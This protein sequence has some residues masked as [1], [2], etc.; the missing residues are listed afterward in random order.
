M[1]R[2]LACSTGVYPKSVCEHDRPIWSRAAEEQQRLHTMELTPFHMTDGSGDGVTLVKSMK[3][4]QVDRTRQSAAC[5]NSLF[6]VGTRMCCC[7]ILLR[8]L[9]T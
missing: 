8:H 4:V 9:S 1:M 7:K 2:N 5:N 6:S 3:G